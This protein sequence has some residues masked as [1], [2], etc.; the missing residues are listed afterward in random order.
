MPCTTIL[1]P[2]CYLNQA[3]TSVG[4]AAGGDFLGTIASAVKSGLAWEFTN[5]ATLWLKVPTPYLTGQAH[6]FARVHGWLL[7]ITGAVAVGGAIAAGARMALTRK[8]GPLLDVTG[9]LAVIGLV[10]ALGLVAPTVMMRLGDAWT[11]WIL[12]VSTGGNFTQRLSTLLS[13]SH[14][15]GIPDIVTIFFGIAAIAANVIQGALLVFRQAAV[16]IL[17]GV[18]PLAAAGAIAPATRGWIK[19]TCGWML[20]LI[21]YKPAAAC[22]Y[23]TAFTLIGS[24]TGW[25][26]LLTGFV[27][28]ILSVVALPVLMRFFTWTTGAV[29]SG[30]GG[31]GAG[32]LIGLAATGA[33]ALGGRMTSAARQAETINADSAPPAGGDGAG[34]G[35][36]GGPPPAGTGSSGPGG[37][38]GPGPGGSTGPGPE[39]PGTQE[40]GRPGE[41]APQTGGNTGEA[42]ADG[43]PADSA[44]VP[45]PGPPSGEGQPGGGPSGSSPQRPGGGTGAD[46]PADP[47]QGG[48]SRGSTRPGGSGGDRPSGSSGPAT[49]GR[50]QDGSPPGTGAGAPEGG[51]ARRDSQEG[52]DGAPGAA[53]SGPGPRNSGPSPAGRRAGGDRSGAPSPAAASFA[54]MVAAQSLASGAAGAASAPVEQEDLS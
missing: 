40:P 51:A 43:G 18:L 20:A 34:P 45:N 12:S 42:A 21:C 50:E 13:I 6:E 35:R 14:G 52:P 38:D 7:P 54:A 37:P 10:A 24:G 3:A 19:K 44:R 46:V 48:A 15:Y 2:L 22:V 5:T 47:G 49:P 39:G 33:L 23:A 41:A 17:A 31:G 26:S 28:M 25:R 11:D 36:P 53:P 16:V 27:T 8:H 9:G 32:Q 1:D 30:G 4:Q 29:A